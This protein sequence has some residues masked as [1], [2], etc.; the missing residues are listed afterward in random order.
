MTDRSVAASTD[1]EMR[2]LIAEAIER[3]T[4][5]VP[6]IGDPGFESL[7]AIFVEGTPGD[8]LLAFAASS[9][10]ARDIGV[11]SGGIMAAMLDTA[12]AV[13]VLSALRPGQSCTTI[14]LTVNMMRPAPV[15]RLYVRAKVEKLGRSIGFAHGQLL[16][17]E[18]VQLATASSSMAVISH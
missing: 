4:R 14:S 17:T 18:Q 10:N 11:V 12:M 3:G 15:G 2:R 16:S 6:L 1:N 9:E 5:N 13:A 7:G 8:V